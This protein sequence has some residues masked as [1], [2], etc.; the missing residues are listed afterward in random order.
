MRKSAPG[1]RSRVL[2]ATLLI[3]MGTV[4][5][6][7]STAASQWQ[8]WNPPQV[9]TYDITA[10]DNSGHVWVGQT[11]PQTC[12]V[13]NHQPF[14]SR[15]ICPAD[16]GPH[17]SIVDAPLTLMW[18]CE[19]YGRLDV[20]VLTSPDGFLLE[21]VLDKGSATAAIAYVNGLMRRPSCGDL[22]HGYHTSNPESIAV[23]AHPAVQTTTT[24]SMGVVETTTSIAVGDGVL[25]LRSSVPPATSRRLFAAAIARVT[26]P[27]PQKQAVDVTAAPPFRCLSPSACAALD[28]QSD[29]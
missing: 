25:V 28:R 15:L 12:G 18:G 7:S 26:A 24:T 10:S 9:V 21:R 17:W 13:I 3:A 22:G 11:A 20:A 23:E 4:G 6:A 1:P 14:D 2:V 19:P 29:W 16:L 8:W 27:R 5:D